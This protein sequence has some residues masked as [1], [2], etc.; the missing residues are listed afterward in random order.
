MKSFAQQLAQN[1]KGVDGEIFSDIKFLMHRSREI[2]Y[3][4]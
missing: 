3:M 4:S 2:F 1:Q